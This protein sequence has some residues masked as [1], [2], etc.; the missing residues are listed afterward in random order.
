MAIAQGLHREPTLFSPIPSEVSVELRRRIW[1]QLCYLEWRAAELKGMVSLSAAI[2]NVDDALTTR[3]PRNVDDGELSELR[4]PGLLDAR[5]LLEVEPGRFT[6]T[7]FLV[8][9]S[10]WVQCAKVVAANVQG[11]FRRTKGGT[12][13]AA[14]AGSSV[15]GGGGGAAAEDEAQ[16]VVGGGDADQR[17]AEFEKLHRET[18]ALV[19]STR[20]GNA[21]FFRFSYE[22]PT[23]LQKLCLMTSR[24][25]EW[26]CWLTFWCSVPKDFRKKVMTDDA[27]R[28]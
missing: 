17:F 2:Q 27:R 26:K 11:W 16:Q 12:V 1:H 19:D 21:A 6:G 28:R 5:G 7:T 3:V 24:S 15:G 8:G 25:M 23:P 18:C 13:A 10:R 20:E 9:R 22:D 14:A 4:R